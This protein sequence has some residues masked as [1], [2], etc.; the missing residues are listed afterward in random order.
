MKTNLHGMNYM[1]RFEIII[2]GKEPMDPEEEDWGGNIF[3]FGFS[4]K[5]FEKEVEDYFLLFE[6]K[7]STHLH[8]CAWS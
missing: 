5:S 1:L 2:E 8:S 6:D 3:E 7:C 4:V